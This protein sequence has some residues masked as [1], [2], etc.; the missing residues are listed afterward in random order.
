[1]LDLVEQVWNGGRVDLLDRYYAPTFDHGGRPD[2]LEGLRAWHEAEARTWQG[3]RYDVVEVV[4]QGLKVAIRWQLTQHQVGPW[5]PV[6]A[7]GRIVTTE[8]AHFFELDDNGF[9]VRVWALGDAFSKARQLGA[10]PD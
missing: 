10:I 5:G 7:T 3:T 9:I 6:A 8:G 2:S 1:M 4:S